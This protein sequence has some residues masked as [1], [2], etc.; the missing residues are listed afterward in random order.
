MASVP[1]VRAG[2]SGDDPPESDL[3]DQL[4]SV[5]AELADVDAKI[6]ELQEW[7]R[8]LTE[9][10]ARLKE[11]VTAGRVARLADQDWETRR[12]PWSERLAAVL[13][14]RF[15]IDSGFRPL[16]LSAI[17]AS[18]S[19]HDV[20]LVMPTGGGKSLCFQLPALVS[21]GVTLV[22][23]PLVSLM[24]DQVTALRRRGVP[25]E[26]L[27]ATTTRQDAS[28]ILADMISERAEMRLLYVTPEKMAKS[29]RFMT[30]LQAMHKA[31]RFA[32][33]A[34]DE[35]HCCSQW[36]HDFRPDY[37]FLGIMK[38]MFPGVPIMG[39]TAT[40]TA[41]VT[42]D[43]KKMLH[44]PEAIVFKATFNRPNLFYSVRPKPATGEGCVEELVRLIGTVYKGKSGIVYTTTIKDTE[45]LAERLCKA[46][47]TAAPYHA[48]LEAPHRSR[49]HQR[50]LAD[51]VRVVVA[52]IA[53]GMGIDKP[54]VRFVIHHSL[55]KSLENYYQESG[56]A[57]RDG[58]P[59]D[60]LIMYRLQ[61]V[62]SLSTMVF[63]DAATGLDNLY[64]MVR[65]CLS[66]SRCRR[67]LIAEHF[68]EQWTQADCAQRCDSCQR[69]V[70]AER[71]DITRHARA[72]QSLLSRAAASDTRL[73]AIKLV[74]AWLGSGP[75]QLRLSAAEVPAITRPRAEAVLAHL[76]TESYIKEDF[77][78]TPY[79]T[80]SYLVAGPNEGN[81][82]VTMEVA[83]STSTSSAG[84]DS[85]S[86]VKRPTAA[87]GKV[88][89]SADK[90]PPKRPAVS[91]E[92][93]VSDKSRRR[94]KLSV[95]A[96]AS[97]RTE[98]E[99]S[100]SAVTGVK[101]SK[102]SPCD[103]VAAKRRKTLLAALAARGVQSAGDDVSNCGDTADL[104]LPRNSSA[105][106]GLAPTVDRPL[107]QPDLIVLDS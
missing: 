18:M 42:R 98:S 41:D 9:K 51:K 34:I 87:A 53:F 59:A 39:L 35:V 66:T 77:H 81:Y 14:D 58:Q 67:Q 33:L 20:M 92:K 1:E 52:T 2:G 55:S 57:G 69:P 107:S 103:E 105:V 40:S 90:T 10:Q 32:R 86:P 73:T 96:K 25:A 21:D 30:K 83:G 68:E 4:S 88:T 54:D 6:A 89:G 38:G 93:A 64:T 94:S 16:Q 23:T 80:I 62:F 71:R 17:N 26:M 48:R 3:A 97:R 43:V 65:Y 22:V 28:R 95:S 102:S 70:S 56:R 8:L 27:S 61:D 99:G 37:K 106:S 44:I 7:R 63:T 46:G 31:K 11:R 74:D 100:A 84:A 104:E 24:E 45:E 36:G 82:P 49:I 79:K 75:A 91:G 29:K 12:F 85:R 101:R 13:R 47:I 50:W 5:A 78:F 60:C 76:L 15:G 19:G 72:L